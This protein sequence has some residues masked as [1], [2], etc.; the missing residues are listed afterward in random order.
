METERGFAELRACFYSCY[1]GICRARIITLVAG[2]QL[3]GYPNSL[4]PEVLRAEVGEFAR[5]RREISLLMPD[6]FK[7]PP[8]NRTPGATAGSVIPF[9]PRDPDLKTLAETLIDLELSRTAGGQKPYADEHEDF[10]RALLAQELVIVVAHFEAFVADTTRAVYMARPDLVAPDLNV[11]ARTLL[12]LGSWDAVLEYLAGAS[13]T[14]MRR[15][16]LPDRLERLAQRVGTEP[17]A[18]SSQAEWI[19]R[20][21][22]TRHAIVHSGGRVDREYVTRTGDSSVAIGGL[23]PLSDDSVWT[24]SSVLR[25]VAYRT[26]EQ[27]AV[28]V[29]GKCDSDIGMSYHYNPPSTDAD[30]T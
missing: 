27:L 21:V 29:W 16:S 13:G 6:L 20:I 10:P 28:A 17:L 24:A 3:Q 7:N 22:Q 18:T 30:N 26:A 11:D 19:R 2:R 23:I 12:G 9:P 14:A 5:L 25:A 1:T 4:P 15:G 8:R